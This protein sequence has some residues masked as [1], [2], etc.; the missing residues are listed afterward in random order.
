MPLRTEPTRN[1]DGS[2]ELRVSTRVHGHIVEFEGAPGVIVRGLS[3]VLECVMSRAD[4]LREF[5]D[6]MVPV[7]HLSTWAKRS[8][9]GHSRWR[10]WLTIGEP[11]VQDN[12]VNLAAEIRQRKRK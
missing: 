9:R 12:V 11:D 3:L 5:V 6:D 10:S 4:E 8:G 1:V 2:G 7:I